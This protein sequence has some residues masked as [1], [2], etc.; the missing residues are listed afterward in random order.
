VSLTVAPE[1]S[2]LTATT[3]APSS[4]QEFGRPPIVQTSSISLGTNFYVQVVVA[5][6]SRH[7]TATGTVALEN[8]STKLGTYSLDQTGSIYV[9]CGPGTSCDLPV[10]NYT[11]K[12]VYSGDNSFDA[13]TT[14]FPFT[15]TKGIAAYIAVLSNSTPPANSTVI[16]T[17]S[18]KYDPA[19]L[20]TGT[21]TLTRSDTG[22]LLATGSVNK[23]G[24]AVI[25]FIAPAGSYNVVPA[26]SGDANYSPGP[27]EYYSITTITAGS[28][29]TTTTMTV[30]STSTTV[31]GITN[32]SITVTPNQATNQFPTGS[33]YLTL[34]DG[35]IT[36]TYPLV[37][38]AV[39]LNLPWTSAGSYRFQATYSGDTH[40]AASASKFITVTVTKGNVTVSVVPEAPNVQ[41]GKQTSLT[42][43]LKLPVPVTTVTPPSGTVQFYDSLDGSAP[44]A[45]GTLANV[46]AGN[47]ANTIL[48]TTA[49][50]LP[51]GEN[52]VTAVYAGDNNW[53]KSEGGPVQV[54]VH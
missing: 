8:G 12:A 47:G 4:L 45:I 35:A 48:A 33:V 50:S 10:G 27:A 22:A 5:G 6:V 2:K 1:K 38:G 7:G 31:G 17:I 37:H 11:F 32:V 41:K 3:Y 54:V 25:P 19:V 40:F 18:F 26:Y 53:Q 49:L 52:R 23:S 44:K 29:T 30:K 9:P 36:T 14:T 15:I 21:V 20:P 34:V 42:A 13:S 24:Q 39:T 16:A 46:T 51:E 43:Y 28:S